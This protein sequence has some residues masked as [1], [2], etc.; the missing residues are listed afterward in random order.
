MSVTSEL[1]PGY[2]LGRP[3]LSH[4]SEEERFVTAMENV[5]GCWHVTEEALAVL[6]MSRER[7][8]M[9]TQLRLKIME[10]SLG[11]SLLIQ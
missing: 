1:K 6:A 11:Y 10:I 3:P 2:T 8:A 4:R 5:T 9:S 7:V